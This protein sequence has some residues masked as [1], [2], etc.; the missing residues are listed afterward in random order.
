MQRKEQIEIILKQALELLKQMDQ[1]YD[2]M[3]KTLTAM[4]TA[5]REFNRRLS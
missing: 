2:R 3:E 5:C 4:Q 1:S